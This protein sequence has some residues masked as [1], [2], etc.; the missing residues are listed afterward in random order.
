MKIPKTLSILPMVAVAFA[1]CGKD[2]LA[3]NHGRAMESENVS[4]ISTTEANEINGS[5]SALF[6]TRASNLDATYGIAAE[7][8]AG[9][10]NTF[11]KV[12]QS[13]SEDFFI[14]STEMLLGSGVHHALLWLTENTEIPTEGLNGQ[15]ISPNETFACTATARPLFKLV[16]SVAGSQGTENPTAE[17]RM[18]KGVGIRVPANS[19]LVLEIHGLNSNDTRKP[20][21]ASAGLRKMDE[22]EVEYE[23][24]GFRFYH[25]FITVPTGEHKVAR[26][27]CPITRDVTLVS[28]VSHMHQ[29]GVAYRARLL[30]GDPYETS[31]REIQVLY[32][33]PDWSDPSY[34]DFDPVID[35]K[36]GQWID[37]QCDYE[38]TSER[39]VAQGLDTNDEMCMFTGLYYPR[40]GTM[41]ACRKLTSA[42]Q[43][44]P[45]GYVIGS[46]ELDGPAFTRCLLDSP[47]DFQLCGSSTSCASNESRYETQS[48]FNNACSPVGRFSQSLATCV[49]ANRMHCAA[50]CQESTERACMT[51]C[52]TGECQS[53]VDALKAVNCDKQL[54]LP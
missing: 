12:F 44:V 41:D 8:D 50:M 19:V 37:Y 18:P 21:C 47:L 7:L 39:N 36:A 25:P 4:G 17:G 40:D 20:I 24:G 46:G 3:S 51:E 6:E 16:R 53:I 42:G 11:C 35:L 31:T 15:P 38:N 34:M 32:D 13:G 9:A 29:L 23:E 33:R 1:G 49:G 22:S 48:C 5:C 2:E 52:I 10:E 45:A 43:E 54:P 28:A 14:K 26:M 27:A 30:D